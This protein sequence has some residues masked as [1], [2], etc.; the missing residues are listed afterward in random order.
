MD[1]VGELLN[2]LKIGLSSARQPIPARVGASFLSRYP[3]SA[4]IP[5]AAIDACRLLNT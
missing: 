2:L 1:A 4:I 5:T 3:L